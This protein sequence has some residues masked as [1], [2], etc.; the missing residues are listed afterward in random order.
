[1]DIVIYGL[2][3]EALFA[4]KMLNKKTN[5]LGFSDSFANIKHY[6]GYKYY[7]K[8]ELLKLKF[9]YIVIAVSDKG[10]SLKIKK[11]LSSILGGGVV[12]FLE[13][14]TEQKVDKVM[15]NNQ[16]DL[17][18]IILGNSHAALGINPQVLKSK[19]VNLANGSEDIYYR[20]KVFER[21]KSDYFKAI[22]NLKWILIELY[23][24]TIFNYD[25][26]LGTQCIFYWAHGGYIEDKHNFSMNTNYNRTVEQLLDEEGY[27]YPISNNKV[28]DEIFDI[29]LIKKYFGEMF[30]D[31]EPIWLGY[32][33]FPL[34]SQFRGHISSEPNFPGNLHFMGHTRYPETIEENTY[35]LE[36]LVRSIREVNHNTRIM[37]ILMPRYILMENLHR[38]FMQDYKN[39]FDDYIL[40]YKKSYNIEFYDFKGLEEISGNPYFYK[41]TAHLNYYGSV[42]FTS[43]LSSELN[44]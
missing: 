42:A 28:R 44:I 6:F 22:E 35:I 16:S 26:S 3:K 32:N 21:V 31:K 20:Y 13:L 14:F 4:Y 7:R 5:F 24:Y 17:E 40:R 27:Y 41:D 39:E 8:E 2:G 11:E 25:V 18:G 33:D 15:S 23:D 36:Q 37:F 9:D 43:Y 10:T 12:D 1:M 29:E 19:C 30:S 34:E 38:S